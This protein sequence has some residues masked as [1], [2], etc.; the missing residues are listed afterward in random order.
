MPDASL[1]A[2]RPAV[3]SDLDALAA[4]DQRCF[5]VGIAYSKQEIESLLSGSAALTLVAERSQEIAGF[6][7]LRTF[8]RRGARRGELI[9]IDILPEFRRERMG[10]QLHQELED[11][12]RTGGG[13]AIELH[14]A[15]SN[16]AAIGFY[17]HLGYRAITRVPNYY[18][19]TLDALRM[20]KLLT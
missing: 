10:L 9:T 6:A 7:S 19:E 8:Q 1:F 5:P 4:I 2:I 11:W 14:V 13:V 18:L 15:V 16:V 20:E 17:E 3:L 12:L